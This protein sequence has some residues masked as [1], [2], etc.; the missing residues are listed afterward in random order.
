MRI[1]QYLLPEFRRGGGA[2]FV[3]TCK[4]RNVLFQFLV[5]GLFCAPAAFGTS[6]TIGFITFDNGAPT[7][8]QNEV[9][10]NDLTGLTYCCSVA[11]G[12]PVCDN[13]NLTNLSLTVNYLDAQS[14]PQQTVLTVPGSIGP[15]TMVPS[16][17]I[18]PGS[19]NITSLIF[20]ATISP[21]IF[22]L[23]D[24]SVVQ[25]APTVSSAPLTPGSNTLSLLT[26]TSSSVPEPAC[27]TLIALGLLLVAIRSRTPSLT[28][29]R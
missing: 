20:A 17:F 10:V 8:G 22:H 6:I 7:A 12:T 27:A 14:H 4:A 29:R 5:V 15:G 28:C 19:E 25:A 1:H 24:N 18:F 21:T 9:S 26:V 13:L 3:S 16:N 11:N 2:S 23:T